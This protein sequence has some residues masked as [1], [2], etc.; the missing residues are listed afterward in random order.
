MFAL[1]AKVCAQLIFPSSLFKWHRALKRCE[2]RSNHMRHD[3]K[4]QN[5]L[6]V[7]KSPP[8][9][10]AQ[11]SICWIAHTSTLNLVLSLVCTLTRYWLNWVWHNFWCSSRSS[12][13]NIDSRDHPKDFALQKNHV[14][15]FR[16]CIRNNASA[17]HSAVQANLKYTELVRSTFQ[18]CLPV[19]CFVVGVWTLCR[20]GV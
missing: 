5:I 17:V 8:I 9:Y 19:G 16:E 18:Q 3:A 6:M 15:N 20:L 14:Q 12:K 11:H 7:Y 1:H 4:R 13:L 10:N 2:A